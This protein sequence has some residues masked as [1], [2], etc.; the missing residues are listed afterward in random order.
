MKRVFKDGAQCMVY[1]SGP[2]VIWV[3]Q[4]VVQRVVCRF[5]LEN[6]SR[7]E[8]VTQQHVQCLCKAAELLQHNT[9]LDNDFDDSFIARVKKKI[10]VKILFG[11]N[12]HF[13]IR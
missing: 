1:L 9:K 11:I 8:L 4:Y 7:N 5:P 2:H 13:Q 12:L 6:L 3:T 10:T